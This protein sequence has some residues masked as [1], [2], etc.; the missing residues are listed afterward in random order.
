MAGKFLNTTHNNNL[1]RMVFGLQKV[2]DNP[3]YKWLSQTPT[4][5][6]YYNKSVE[7][8]TLDEGSKLQ[9]SETGDDSPFRYNKI[10][11]MYLYGIERIQVQLENDE[12]GLT[13]GSVEGEAL[14]L[15]GTITPYAGDFFRIDYLKEKSIL[16]KVLNVSFDT[17]ENG[18]NFYKLQYKLDSQDARNIENDIK[19][20][21]NMLINNVGTK[22]NPIIRSEKY[23][24]IKELET[25]LINLK[26]YYKALFYSDR[27]QT[28]VFKY[29]E[30]YFYDPV[31]IEFLSNNGLMEGD[32]EYIYVDHKL[33]VPPTFAL[34]Y[35][36]TIFHM[37]EKKDFKNIRRYKYNAVGRYI[38]A[39]TSIFASRPEDYFCIDYRSDILDKQLLGNIACF[40]EDFINYA[41][42]GTLFLKD[43]PRAIYNSII[44][45]INGNSIMQDDLDVLEYMDYSNNETI[46]Y[47]IPC[48]I[49]CIESFIKGLLIKPE[50]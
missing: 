25:V 46:F 42:S 30:K 5:V 43:D 37:F 33:P 6:T 17:L 4:T 7:A 27:V 47:A 8:S 16:F 12:F 11:D 23:D 38:D 40:S 2:I 31:V 50:T 10:N 32:D 3:Y 45:F 22:F 1:N 13:N 15:P 28:F 48:I 14:V 49:Y 44:K 29:N 20:T 9:Y 19:D 34:M 39:K 26:R 36:K 41:E 18:S 21:Y 35:D 24:L